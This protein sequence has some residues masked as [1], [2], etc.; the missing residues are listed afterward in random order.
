L[1]PLISA[2]CG[3][4]LLFLV[5]RVARNRLGA[6]RAAACL[7]ALFLGTSAQYAVWS[8]SGLETMPYALLIFATFERLILRRDGIAPIAAGVLAILLA[9]TR[10]E[11][12]VWAIAFVPLA[13][14][15]AR[16]Q[17]HRALK[18]IAIYCGVLA[19]GYLPYALW[20]TA[21][22]G[23]VVA[24]TVHAK[25]HLDSE[26]LDRGVQYVVTQ[27][28][29]SL[30]LFVVVPGLL[31][32]LLPGKR[33]LALPVAALAL[34]FVAF[35]ILVG[36]DYMAF[37]RFLVPA[38]AFAALLLAW[39]VEDL[40][41]QAAWRRAGAALLGAGVVAL[42]ALPGF[43]VHPV[44]QETREEWRFRLNT[45]KYKTEAEKWEGMRRN[46]VNWGELGLAL[47]AIASPGDSVVL[48]PMGATAYESGL[49][50]FDT[51]GLISPEVG[52]RTVDPASARSPGH[53]MHV[54]NEFFIEL[55][56]EPTFLRTQV[57]RGTPQGLAGTARSWQ[58]LVTRNPDLESKYICDFYALP[59]RGSDEPESRGRFLCVLR[60]LTADEDP[61]AAQLDFTRR[62]KLLKSSGEMPT[63]EMEPHSGRVGGVPEWFLGD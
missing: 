1:G 47:K 3:S 48:G 10:V 30:S 8:T 25:V 54:P 7:A 11:G 29:T 61:A 41:G 52:R 59:P 39:L 53:D 58:Q 62:L 27:F 32:A 50:V 56:Y 34:G 45:P 44:P 15:T 38:L 12:V 23:S 22:F 51:N 4:L 21:Y 33:A 49:F 18:P 2:A 5:F 28:L 63:L 31:A 40:G 43:G 55:G 24:N 9:L 37:G 13:V 6:S 35:S 57:V 60:R 20:R 46:P 36:G 16:A 26:T 19:L 17:S 42:G 14:Y